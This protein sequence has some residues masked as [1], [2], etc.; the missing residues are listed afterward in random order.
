MKPYVSLDLETTGLDDEDCQILEIGAVIDDWTSPIEEL[1]RFRCYVNHEQFVGEPYALSM[2]PKIFRYIATK[3]KGM[4][5]VNIF[6][7]ETVAGHFLNWLLDNGLDPEKHHLP[8]AG[9]NFARFARNVRKYIPHWRKLIQAQ[10][11]S[12]DPGNLWWNP[13]IDTQ[14]LPSTK[15]C[16]E[17]AGI[18]GEVAHTAVEDAIMVV[19]L[20]REWFD[21]QEFGL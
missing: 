12:I 8:L 16:M 3:G 10:H 11:R 6:S 18:D 1:P 17:R 2:H 7:P 13:I 4:E 19:R 15:T 5:P 14:G 9:K 21:R 20:V